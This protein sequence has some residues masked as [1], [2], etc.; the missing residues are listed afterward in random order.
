MGS[1]GAAIAGGRAGCTTVAVVGVVTTGTAP[2]AMDCVALDVA[3][4]EAAPEGDTVGVAD[5][6]GAG[7][8]TS[9]TTA[10]RCGVMTD[11][12]SLRRVVLMATVLGSVGFG[13]LLIYYVRESSRGAEVVRRLREAV[14]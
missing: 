7:E 1:D 12:V 2:V 13:E 14:A 6:E 5:A 11:G 10:A 8:V 9:C 4:A 3:V